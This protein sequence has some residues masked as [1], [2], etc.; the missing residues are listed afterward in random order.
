MK[1][2]RYYKLLFL[3]G[4]V[5]NLLAG[6]ICLLLSVATTNLFFELYGMQVAPSLF[7]F[8]AFF[9]A[10]LSFGIGFILVS[11]DITKNHVMILVGILG[12]VL[13]FLVCL[14]TFFQNEANI[15]LV[16]TGSADLVF[17]ILYLEFLMRFRN[18][19][20]NA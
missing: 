16:L 20:R 12:K 13:F 9:A 15:L 6:L 8:H 18:R 14:V 4:G 1:N 2:D 19:T 11:L 10:V 5:W 3:M 7:P 17:A